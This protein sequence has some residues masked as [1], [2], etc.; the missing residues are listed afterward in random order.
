[1]KMV[2]VCDCDRKTG[3]EGRVPK[4]PT[5]T[6]HVN[7]I[8]NYCTITQHVNDICNYCGHYVKYISAEQSTT[9]FGNFMSNNSLARTKTDDGL[10][11]RNDYWYNFGYPVGGK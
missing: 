9:K 4:N 7:D 10:D 2:A 6:Q 11:L 8:C 3:K 5:I 1:M